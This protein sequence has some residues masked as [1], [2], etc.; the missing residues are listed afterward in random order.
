[1]VTHHPYLE[2]E[3]SSDL[4]MASLQRCSAL[5]LRIL[6]LQRRVNSARRSIVQGN[7]GN[8]SHLNET[9]NDCQSPFQSLKTQCLCTSSTWCVILAKYGR[10]NQV[11]NCEVCNDV[12]AR[13]QKE[14][15]IAHKIPDTPWW[16]VGQDLFTYGSETFLVTFEYYSDY[17]EARSVAR[18]NYRGCDQGSKVT[19]FAARYCSHDYRQWSQYLSD[20]FASFT[21]EWKFQHTTS[22]PLHSKSNDKAESA[23]NIANNLVRKA[24]RENKDLKMALPC[25]NGETHPTLTS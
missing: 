7:E 6:E 23:V 17:F 16:K 15:L 3:L 18:G 21:R 20:Q 8:C 24:R 5:H 9:S 11:Q 2:I 13:R 22:S 14:P 10:P 1:M 12:L 19:L 25:W 4:W